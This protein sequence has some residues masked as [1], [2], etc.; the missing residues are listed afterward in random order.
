MADFPRSWIRLKRVPHRVLE[1]THRASIVVF[2]ARFILG[3]VEVI[4]VMTEGMVQDP[5]VARDARLQRI[6]LL[7]DAIEPRRLEG[8]DVLVVMIESADAP[9]REYADERPGNQRHD[10]I[11]ERIHQDI[12]AED[13]GKAEN[14]KSVLLISKDAHECLADK[15]FKRKE[16][17]A[18]TSAPMRP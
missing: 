8:R 3:L 17:T 13:Q 1:P 12:A 14:R 6:H 16:T 11:D 9:F 18:R 2:P 5:R 4:D 15:R 10:V 7:E